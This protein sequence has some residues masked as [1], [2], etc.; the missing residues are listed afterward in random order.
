M[1]LTEIGS[2][3]E[4]KF[5]E[6]WD[7]C[8]FKINIDYP[9]S[10]YMLKNDFILFEQNYVGNYLYCDHRLVWSMFQNEFILEDDEIIALI[11]YMLRD[12]DK[13]NIFTIKYSFFSE[14]RG[15]ADFPRYRSLIPFLG[16]EVKTKNK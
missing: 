9:K 4:F 5:L 8:D 2:P 11:N 15:F 13:L 16:D 10:I 7:G 14:M 12:D 1:L 6:L 3:A